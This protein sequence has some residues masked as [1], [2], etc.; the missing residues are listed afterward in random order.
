MLFVEHKDSFFMTSLTQCD[1]E[2]KIIMTKFDVS[3]L[4]FDKIFIFKFI[5]TCF[6]NKNE[7]H[8]T[9]INRF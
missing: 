8:C 9:N 5:V 6:K 2:H 1:S 3:L 7:L 4:L